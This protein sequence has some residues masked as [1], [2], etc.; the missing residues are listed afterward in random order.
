M[1][2][3]RSRAGKAAPAHAASPADDR[4]IAAALLALA[5]ARGPDR[6]FCP[7]EAARRLVPEDAPADAWRRLMASV[8]RVAARLVDD[9]RLRATRRGRPVDPVAAGGPIRLGLPPP[10]GS[11]DQA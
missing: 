1:D 4:A 6:T 7:S 2:T 3:T 10:D 5:A 11:A 9:G 8:R